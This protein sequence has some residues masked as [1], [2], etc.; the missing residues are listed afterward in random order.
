[1][2]DLSEVPSA[3]MRALRFHGSRDVRLDVVAPPTPP[4]PGE[5]LLRPVVVGICGTDVR[6]YR[7]GKSPRTPQIL[8]HE[9]VA[10]IVASGPDMH[11]DFAV[12]Q[13]VAVIP[14]VPCLN[15]DICR[16][17]RTNF[18]P[19]RRTLGIQHPWGGFADL[20]IAR[21]TQLVAIPDEMSWRQAAMIEPL[22]V[23]LNALRQAEFGPNAQIAII[24][25][26]P[27]GTL[28]A[29]AARTT[30]GTV[31]VHEVSTTRAK[32]LQELGLDAVAGN[33]TEATSRGDQCDVV[34]DCAGNEASLATAISN[35]RVGGTVVLAAA[36]PAAVSVD[37]RAALI[38]GLVIRTAFAYPVTTQWWQSGIQE[39]SNGALRVADVA[40]RCITLPEVPDELATMANGPTNSLKTLVTV[41]GL[42][43]V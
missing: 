25:G 24:G 20:A 6:Q 8:G 15:C 18:C 30:A 41:S 19:N 32:K 40:D 10:E 42:H 16:L 9:C 7:F 36:G 39:I 33:P 22:A 23:A 11:L 2:T 26:G 12:G 35:A 37:V 27:I 13:R 1:M 31:R 4:G 43:S 34:V 38:K 21:E 3:T 17:G 29:M 28:A 5:V 14:Q